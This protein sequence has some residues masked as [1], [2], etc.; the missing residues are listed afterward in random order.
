[1]A[2]PHKRPN[3]LHGARE[4]GALVHDVTM[5]ALALLLSILL[6][7]GDLIAVV[8]T[9]LIVGYVIGFAVIAAAVFLGTGLYRGIWRYASLPDVIA[10]LRATTLTIFIA[11]MVF[12]FVTR[13]ELMPRSTLVICWFV[14]LALLAG[15]RFA[16]RAIKD[17]GLSNILS[18]R[19]GSAV[20]VLLI[21]VTDSTHADIRE[22]ARE[23]S[24]PYEVVGLIAASARRVGR[25]V[26]GV[27]VLGT[28][29]ELPQVI[30]RLDRRELTATSPTTS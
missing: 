24:A 11:A 3:L 5:S 4:L 1:M 7:F 10:L 23:R 30:E 19:D 20:P 29:A 8:P 6:R 26:A 15:P 9:E 2:L 16:Y 22:R 18:R 27:P 25:D 14:M 21:G 12:F 17:R 28:L 13:L